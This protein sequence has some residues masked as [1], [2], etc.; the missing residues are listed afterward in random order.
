VIKFSRISFLFAVI[1]VFF[2]SERPYKLLGIRQFAFWRA[3]KIG[4][5]EADR[6]AF[7]SYRAPFLLG[8]QSCAIK[9]GF[10]TDYGG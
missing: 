4:N 3:R 8:G 7:M 2:N 10:A 9:L 6:Q 1:A 5:A